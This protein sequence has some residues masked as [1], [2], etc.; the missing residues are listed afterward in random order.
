PDPALTQY[1]VWAVRIYLFGALAMGAQ[2]T[3]QQTFIAVGQAKSSIFLALLRKIIL[4][5]PL[6]YL[7]PLFF[8]NKVLGVFVAEPVADILATSVT[9]LMFAAQFGKILKANE[10]A[11][12]A[13][14]TEA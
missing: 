2:M 6:I 9:V 5:I 3:C 12:T 10:Q 14:P 1:A 4:L 8:Q 13:S 11:P 7:L